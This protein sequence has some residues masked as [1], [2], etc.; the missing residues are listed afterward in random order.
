MSTSG[1]IA[2]INSLV[3]LTVNVTVS[4][5]ADLDLEATKKNREVAVRWLNREIRHIKALLDDENCDKVDIEESLTEINTRWS[6]L[7]DWNSQVES[8]L[9]EQELEQ[10][11]ADAGAL[12]DEVRVLRKDATRRLAK[13]VGNAV[14]DVESETGASSAAS[15][16]S[17]QTV[18]L[19]KLELPR[20]SGQVT[21]WPSFWDK[22]AAT[23][24]SSTL[25]D[26]TKFT[27]LHSLLDGEARRAIQGLTLTSNHYNI[28]CGLL[29][30]RFGRKE[31][32]IFS[33]IQGLLDLRC[34]SKLPAIS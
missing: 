29:Q 21:E 6:T 13:L 26:V 30:E 10:A 4:N 1:A 15:G 16:A 22:F 7:D 32:I 2:A 3:L 9:P 12:Y 17:L 11:V 18:Q 5:M 34:D 24:D 23:I 19:P 33:H 28:A 20:F 27:Y 25:P 31:Q 14:S 8:L